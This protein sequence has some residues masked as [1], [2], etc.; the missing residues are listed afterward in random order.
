[1]K[2]E[3]Q[4]QANTSTLWSDNT[5][6]AGCCLPKV[7]RKHYGGTLTDGHMCRWQNSKCSTQTSSFTTMKT[8]CSPEQKHPT[9][10]STFC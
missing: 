8:F 10:L 4:I 9:T 5:I 1:M 7:F 3:P 6:G 2:L